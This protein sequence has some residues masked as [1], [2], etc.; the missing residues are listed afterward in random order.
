L[1]NLEVNAASG[2]CTPLAA[3]IYVIDS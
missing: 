2:V 1:E 3:V